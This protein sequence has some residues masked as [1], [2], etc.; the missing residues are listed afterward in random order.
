MVTL[1]MLPG[2]D[3]SGKLFEPLI[4][5]LG[6]E[7]TLLVVTYPPDRPLV[8]QRSSQSPE[9]PFHP[10]VRLF[11]WVSPFLAPLRSHSQPPILNA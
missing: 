9:Q 10:K 8:T 1:V 11:C 2:M 6:N 7:F 5:A 4:G 3:G